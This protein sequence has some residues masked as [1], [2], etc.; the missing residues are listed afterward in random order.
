M[1]LMAATIGFCHW[2]TSFDNR[3]LTQRMRALLGEDYS[4][5]QA[6]YDLRRLRRK[7]IIC[8]IP[9]GHRYQ[10]TQT[11]RAIAVLF[12]KAHGRILG[13]GPAALD[14]QLP[15]GL[16]RRSSLAIAW[17]NLTTELGRFID[18]G[19]APA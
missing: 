16:A 8:R 4:S 15:A 13:P 3:G 18:H 2:I 6:T 19:L 12:T 9:G 7:Q 5:R 1:A 10:L 14:P 11:G 17:G